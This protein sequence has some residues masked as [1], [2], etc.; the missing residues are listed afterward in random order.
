MTPGK[1]GISAN[2]SDICDTTDILIICTAN[3]CR[4]VLAQC[5]LA[6]NLADAGVIAS[7]RSAG[8]LFTG[9]A[10]GQS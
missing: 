10:V 1:V 2:H 6:A 3:S 4:S 5:L 9:T 7:V 8:M